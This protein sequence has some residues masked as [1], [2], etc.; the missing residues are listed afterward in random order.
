MSVTEE[1]F[2]LGQAARR[3]N[4]GSD[5][6][7]RTL[8][9]IDRALGRLMLGFEYQLPRPIDEREHSDNKGKRVIEVSYLGYLRIPG[10]DPPPDQARFHLAIRQ[11]KVFETRR[12][13]E[14]PG[15]VMPLLEAPRAL[16]HAA[17]DHLALLV[18]GL[19]EQV[20]EMVANIERRND[21]ASSL[22]STLEAPE[23]GE[24]D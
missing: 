8:A 19:A 7:D 15:K 16:R 14:A 11:L 5:R 17:V 1:L 24:G 6:L 22:L 13:D 21:V 20:D 10:I 3:L 12:P 2:R 23:A 4:D 18:A 9:D